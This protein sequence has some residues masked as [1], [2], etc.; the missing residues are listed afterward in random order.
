LDLQF[1]T[2]QGLTSIVELTAQ[3]ADQ[4]LLPQIQQQFD[5]MIAKADYQYPDIHV[6]DMDLPLN[7]DSRESR[8]AFSKLTFRVLKVGN[9]CASRPSLTVDMT[10]MHTSFT[11]ESLKTRFHRTI[12][13]HPTDP[14]I[15]GV[16][17]LCEFLFVS[18]GN[19]SK[20]ILGRPTRKAAANRSN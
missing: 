16:L 14:T 2:E 18:L 10:L 17:Y 5:I 13:K 8:V 19:D 7:A 3:R 20:F 11:Y 4:N 9:V 6:V 1:L 12:M 15:H